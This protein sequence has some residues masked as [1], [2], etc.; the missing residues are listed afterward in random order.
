MSYRISII[1]LLNL[2]VNN[3]DLFLVINAAPKIKPTY[4]VT[5]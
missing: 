4:V 1:K 5:V 2:N 3:Y